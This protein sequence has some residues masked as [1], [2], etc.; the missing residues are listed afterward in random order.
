[1]GTF[2]TFRKLKIS[3]YEIYDNLEEKYKEFVIFPIFVDKVLYD[4]IST[5][6][7]PL[8]KQSTSIGWCSIDESNCV[9]KITNYNCFNNIFEYCELEVRLEVDLSKDICFNA[10]LHE[11]DLSS[12]TSTKRDKYISWEDYFMGI[13]RLSALRSKDPKT[14][15]GACIVKN[16]KIVSVGYNGFPNYCSDN[17]YPWYSEN[18]NPLEVKDLYVVHSELNAILNCNNKDDLIGSTIYVTLF[19]CNEC[20]KAIIQSGIKEIVYLEDKDSIKQKASKRMLDSANITYRK[21]INNNDFNI[22]ISIE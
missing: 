7:T 15:V 19:P 3:N 20:T 4:K 21:F 9:A 2:Y 5:F 14:Q 18:N 22:N 16:N 8:F 10:Y 12:K 6:L 11:K 17:E 13:A 1:M